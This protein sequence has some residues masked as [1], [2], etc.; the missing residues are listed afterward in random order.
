MAEL[1]QTPCN[2]LC[3]EIRHFVLLLYSTALTEQLPIESPEALQHSLEKHSEHYR[4]IHQL[5]I[6]EG[7]TLW[8]EQASESL[9]QTIQRHLVHLPA[10]ATTWVQIK[11]RNR[12][13]K[14]EQRHYPDFTVRTSWYFRNPENKSHCKEVRCKAL[15]THALVAVTHYNCNQNNAATGYI[16][17]HGQKLW[18]YGTRVC[19]IINLQTKAI[20]VLSIHPAGAVW[21][22]MGTAHRY[23]YAVQTAI[24]NNLPFEEWSREGE[25]FGDE[26]YCY[27][28]IAGGGAGPFILQQTKSRTEYY[29]QRKCRNDRGEVPA[30]SKCS[31]SK[32]PSGSTEQFPRSTSS[33]GISFLP[34]AKFAEGKTL[35]FISFED[36]SCLHQLFSVQHVFHI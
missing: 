35:S 13:K 21:G 36:G 3:I 26:Q 17:Y 34:K 25:D 29:C 6:C 28:I 2:A 27:T 22:P 4:E 7:F 14:Q 12:R 31:S 9:T 32:R 16:Y 33:A 1:F 15:A 20:E 23:S 18:L 19:Y 8:Q 11:D 24:K 5:P 10:I 30:A